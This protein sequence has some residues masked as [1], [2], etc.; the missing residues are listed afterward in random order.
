[1]FFES[2]RDKSMF[3]GRGD[4]F[5]TPHIHHSTEILYVLSGNKTA[6][7]GGKKYDLKAGDLIVCP[8]YQVHYWHLQDDS[9]EQIAATIFPRYCLEFENFCKNHTPSSPIV[10]DSDGMIKDFV[11]AMRD[12]QRNETLLKGIA[13]CILGLYIEKAK[14]V[15]GKPSTERPLVAQIAEYIEANYMHNITLESISKLFGYSP[16]YFSALFKQ[17]FYTGITQYVNYIRIEKSLPLLKK[18]KISTIYYSCGFANPQQYF[19]NF[20]KYLGCTPKEYLN[21]TR[22]HD[23]LENVILNRPS[24][25][26]N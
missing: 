4:N 16:N 26:D 1:M 2:I 25:M 8:P 3:Y 6:F 15:S 21:N 17:N 19:L 9:E 24:N 13:N 12:A 22:N 11:L 14:F 23:L 5:C 20:K 10:H 18:Q 7:L